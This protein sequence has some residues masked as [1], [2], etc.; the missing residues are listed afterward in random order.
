MSDR[1]VIYARFSSHNQ[2]SE[3]IEIQVENCTTYCAENGLQLVGIYSDEAKTGRNSDRVQFQQ[4][5]EDAKRGAFD[6]VVIYKVTRIMRNRDEMALA[7]I[8][9]R[10]CG[11]EILYAGEDISS[12][13]AGVLQ[14]GMLEVLAEWESA[15]DSERIRDGVQKNARRCMANGQ[16]L[17]GWDIVE[18]FYKVNEV[19]A[20]ALRT[21]KNMLFGGKTVADATRALAGYVTKRGKPITHY[22]LTRMLK[23]KQNA[24]IY[25]YAG[26]EKEGGMPALWSI[27]E[28]RML[29][30]LLDDDTRPKKKESA[31][32]FVLTGKLWCGECNKPMCGTSG[33]SKTGK[34]YYYYKC[35]KCGRKV[36]KDALEESV[37]QGVREKLAVAAN[38]ERIADRVC[39]Y[40]TDGD[41]PKQSELLRDELKEI[42]LTFERVWQAI[43]KGIAPPGGKERIEQ[44]EQR[45]KVLQEELSVA[46]SVEAVQLDRDRV[47][48]WL[49][50]IAETSDAK[51]LI[52]TFVARVVLFGDDDLHIAMTFDDNADIGYVKDGGGGVLSNAHMLHHHE[53]DHPFGW[54]FFIG[55]LTRIEPREGATVQWTVV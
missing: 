24:G 6:Y 38:R 3:S 7:R 11:V 27:E 8:M 17:F 5:L 47:L 31:A 30:N 18:G 2:R 52:S 14:L 46:K 42:E 26:F 54:S 19:E 39:E 28:Q 48:F 34:V 49:E 32:D 51:T 50:S 23:R 12:G 15:I 45:Q 25:S 53:Y 21:A 36:R 44:L 33:T 55:Q 1:A 4:M 43:E 13:S 16:A 35:K 10:K 37:A 22:T 29:W 9:L 20:T 41:A 40:E